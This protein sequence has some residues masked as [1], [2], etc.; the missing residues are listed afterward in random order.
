MLIPGIQGRWEYLRP[1]VNALAKSFRTITFALLDTRKEHGREADIDD[2]A[3]QIAAALDRRGIGR[4]VICGISF[5]GLVALRFAA[6]CPERTIALVLASTPGPDFT[7]TSRHLRYTRLPWLFGPL[8]LIETPRR[9]Q[10]E[11]RLAFPRVLDRLRFGW[12]QASTLFTAP[13]SLRGMAR[14]GRLIAAWKPAQDAATVSVPTLVI[15][16]EPALDRVVRVG[17]TLGYVPLIRGAR[18]VELTGTGH[19]GYLTKPRL[20]A[21]SISDFLTSIGVF[22]HDAA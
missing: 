5:G 14:R 8:F 2:L 10:P 19:I 18:S 11:L 16:G 13:L 22:K 20:F 7:L 6:R 9:L 21:S 3:D 1:T 12:R 4:A 17:S 15:T